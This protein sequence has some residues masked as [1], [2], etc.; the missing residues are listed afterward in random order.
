MSDRD[1]K[2]RDRAYQLCDETST[3]FESDCDICVANLDALTLTAR[4]ARVE[5]LRDAADE[6][7]ARD[8][9]DLYMTVALVKW[10]RTRAAEEEKK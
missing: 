8:P 5:A 2:L 3:R 9:D 4:E 10:L 7:D 6:W 1:D